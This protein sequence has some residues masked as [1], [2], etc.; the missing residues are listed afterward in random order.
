MSTITLTLTTSS[1]TA[2][3]AR[4][5]EPASPASLTASVTNSATV[6]TRVVLGAY[7]PLP[8]PSAPA[9]AAAWT[10]V[11]R[12]LRDVGAGATEQYTVTLAPPPDTAAGDY[13]VRLIA[14]DADRAPEEYSDQAQQVQVTVPAGRATPR[15]GI[16]WWIY[17][18]AGVLVLV[19]G[20]VAFLL[21]RPGDPGPLEP[22]PA[23]T[24]TATTPDNPCPSP[25]V[26]RLSRP[27]DLTCVM[28]AS[29]QEAQ[30]DNREDIQ[31]NRVIPGT[32]PV[33]CAIPYEPRL[34][35]PDDFVCV[36]EDTANR[37]HIE[38]QPGYTDYMFN[39]K[40]YPATFT[41]RP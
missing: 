4:G 12:P 33:I 9:S 27:G 40:E 3:P 32:D 39:E 15:P 18:V 19:V 7:P 22:T 13:V 6:P 34:A 21:L 2:T 35:F 29:A 10:V 24:P 23:P 14:Y 36:W 26:P 25:F 28:P 30:F 5:T 8:D 1:V 38:N 17:A 41:P 16:P 11:E 31:R 20:V 37:T